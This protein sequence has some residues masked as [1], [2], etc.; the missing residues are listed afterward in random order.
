MRV[1]EE[2]QRIRITTVGRRTG[3]PRTLEILAQP[4]GDGILLIGSKA[5]APRNPAWYHNLIANP[6]VTVQVTGGAPVV[7]RARVTAGEE[8][9]RLFGETV[10]R[11]PFFGDYQRK[12]ERRIPVVMLEPLTRGEGLEALP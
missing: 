11:F 6:E 2:P 8:R 10:A 7:M 9:D 1:I 3:L 5:G 4:E 12:T